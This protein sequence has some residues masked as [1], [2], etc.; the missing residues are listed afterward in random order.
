MTFSLYPLH[1]FKSNL[2]DE[3]KVLEGLSLKINDIDIEDVNKYSLSN[4]DISKIE[5]ET[6]CLSIDRSIFEPAHITLR[7]IIACRLLK[8][9]RVFI[10]YHIKSKD[11]L[12]KIRDNYPYVQADDST[13]IIDVEE[14]S[15]LSQ[16]LAHPE[17]WWM[18][19]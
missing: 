3:Y 13:R 11:D 15:K 6:H 5:L 2:I 16:I 18:T 8:H 4:D 9:T 17:K 1:G 7:F 10:R 14:F 19:Q 12:L